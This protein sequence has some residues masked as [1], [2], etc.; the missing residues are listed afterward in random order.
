MNAIDQ[1]VVWPE[2]MVSGAPYWAY[3]DEATYRLEQKRIF[4]GAV[5][6]F[7]CLEADVAIRERP[8]RRNA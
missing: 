3:Q 8:V 1:K 6:N 7:V 5:W 2:G 4:G